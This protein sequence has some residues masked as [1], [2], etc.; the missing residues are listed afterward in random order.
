MDGSALPRVWPDLPSGFLAA[1][2]PQ[3]KERA[4]FTPASKLGDYSPRMSL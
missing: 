2:T 3:D 4:H 1:K